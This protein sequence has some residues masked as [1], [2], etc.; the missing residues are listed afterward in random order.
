MG[1]RRSVTPRAARASRSA[2]SR[3]AR[4]AVDRPSRARR[5]GVHGQP[6]VAGHAGHELRQQVEQAGEGLAHA[7]GAHLGGDHRL[8]QGVVQVGGDAVA[9]VGLAAA[10][11]E[12]DVLL[13]RACGDGLGQRA[14]QLA[15]AP[16]ARRR[17]RRRPA[18][19]RSG[20]AGRWSGPRR[21]VG[22]C[23]VAGSARSR[24]HSCTPEML[25]IHR[26]ATTAAGGSASARLAPAAGS[27]VTVT[28]VTLHA[29]ALG[30]HVAILRRSRRG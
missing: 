2:R 3:T 24:R 1:D 11:L 8:E 27:G 30:Q 23:W 28:L 12:E 15:H 5:V 16:L 4:V 18:R 29:Q 14:H 25:G 13:G 9:D 7:E 22:T 26:S 10:Q 6:A 19:P 21:M 17:R 20:C